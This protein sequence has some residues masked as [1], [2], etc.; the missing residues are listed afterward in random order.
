LATVG[1]AASCGAEISARDRA[2]AEAE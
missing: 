2:A 1:A